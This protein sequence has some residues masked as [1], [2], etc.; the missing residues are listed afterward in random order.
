MES[1]SGRVAKSITVLVAD[2][3]RI[4]TQLLS[5]ALQ[6]DAGLSVV[7]W[8]GNPQS[9]IPTTIAYNVDVLAISSTS[10]G[11]ALQGLEI[12]RE[13]RAAGVHTKS[14][15]LMDS[16]A[17]ESV[18]NAFRAGA[19]GI[20]SRE[21][22]VEMF[23][24]CIRCVHQ[25]E[26]WADSRGVALAIGALASTPV[27]R[28]VNA[29]GLELLSK[30]EIEVVECVVQ[31]LTNQEIAARMGLSRH[32]IKN[33]LFRVFDKLGVSSRVELLFMTLRGATPKASLQEVPGKNGESVRSDYSDTE[34]YDEPTIAFFEKAAENGILGA[35][36]ALAQAYLT[37]RAGP[38]DLISAYAWYLIA[39]ER[40]SQVRINVTKMLTA[41]EVDDAEQKASVWLARG[42]QT[43]TMGPVAAKLIPFKSVM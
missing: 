8:D 42:K 10:N 31:G 15:V 1:P 20:F 11:G 29:N 43:V 40:M 30:R 16:Y 33:Y 5:D 27:V 26:I 22:S 3:S 28:A 23:C 6:R 32:T 21:G 39:A 14:V 13:L 38:S 18:V 36:L 7:M 35:Q 34:Q 37:R 9:L 2:T 17:E 24:K 4:H 19:R 12:V 25:G 41:D